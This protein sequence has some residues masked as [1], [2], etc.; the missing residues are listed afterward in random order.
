MYIIQLEHKPSHLISDGYER[1]APQGQNP[2]FFRAR[3]LGDVQEINREWI[4]N[5]SLSPDNLALNSG[6]IYSASTL[7]KVG[8]VSY[9][10]DI[11]FVE[12]W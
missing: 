5:N 10:G 11:H 6:N 1:R 2:T 3:T 4:V 12:E 8:Q 9:Y 7:K